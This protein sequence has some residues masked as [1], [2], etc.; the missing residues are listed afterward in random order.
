MCGIA[1]TAKQRPERD[2]ALEE[3][4]TIEHKGS[5]ARISIDKNGAIVLKGA[6]ITLEADDIDV[7]VKNKM[8]VQ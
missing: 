2:D 5:K 3:G 6:K 7:K 1:G 4:V 8:N